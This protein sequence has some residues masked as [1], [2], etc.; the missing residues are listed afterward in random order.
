[1]MSYSRC[2]VLSW[3][4]SV[5]AM[6]LLTSAF[7]QPNAPPTVA[8][9]CAP[10]HGMDGIGRDVEIPNIAGQHSVY[11]REQLLAFKAGK[12]KHAEMQYIGRH[13]TDQEI[14][15]LVLY[16][17]TLQ[18]RYARTLVIMLWRQRC[19]ATLMI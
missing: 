8:A 11:L 4:F 14:N 5:S 15:E 19:V 7:G 13:L 18:Y 6:L 17:S 10:C 2:I 9:A 3:T 1:M 12:R 16:Y